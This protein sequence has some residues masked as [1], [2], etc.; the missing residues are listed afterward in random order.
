MKN[1]DKPL[2][3]AN[4]LRLY[5]DTADVQDWEA[6]LPTGLFYGITSNPLLLERASVRC[7]LPMLTQL[8]QQAFSLGVKEVQMQTWGASVEALVSTGR[9]IASIDPRMVVKVPITKLGTE[10]ASQL[11]AEGVPVTLTAAYTHHQA[12][13]AAALGAAYIAPYLGRINDQGRKGRD[14]LVAMQRSLDGVHS[15]TRILTASI[16]H[17]EDI[18]YLSA[19]GLNTFTFSAAIAAA[20]FDVPSTQ[21][22][23]E[24]FENA[25]R[26]MKS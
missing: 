11:I 22:A 2:D 16:R 23:T 1:I 20:L 5:L 7:S 15:S 18:A 13:I 6:W 24:D 12:I 3:S 8:A 17:V 26:R 10:A 4:G 9:A 19:H 21:Q 14:E 25:A